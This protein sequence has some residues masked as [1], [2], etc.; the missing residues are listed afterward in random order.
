MSMTIQDKCPIC[1]EDT[2]SYFSHE[3]LFNHEVELMKCKNCGHGSYRNIWT[4]SQFDQIYGA[5]Y[6]KDYLNLTETHNQRREQYVLDL[7]LLKEFFHKSLNVLDFG[8]SSGEYLDSMPDLWDKS[9]YEVNSKLVSILN[10]TRPG[11]HI[12]NNLGDIEEHFDLI[13]LRGVIE[14]IPEFSILI[15]FINKQLKVGGTL[16]ISATPDFS[17]PCAVEY[18]SKWGQ[19][20]SPEHLHQFTPASL[21]ILLSTSGLVMKGLYHPYMGTPYENWESDSNIYIANKAAGL[22]D[23][24]NSKEVNPQNHPFPGNMMS[25]VFEKII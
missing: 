20:V 13:T 15:E 9:G 7:L 19:I 23:R 10:A 12:Y 21:Q 3:D 11:Y 8:C 22:R 24:L 16:Y 2:Y 6:A 1:L 25:V 14:H 18:K 17:S 4:Q 5:E